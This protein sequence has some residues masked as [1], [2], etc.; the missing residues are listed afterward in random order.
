M[1]LV[2]SSPGSHKLGSF[3]KIPLSAEMVVVTKKKISN[4]KAMSA[5]DAALTDAE[6]LLNDFRI[7]LFKY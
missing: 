7:Y 2:Q 4:K 6:Y 5:M 3:L 1:S